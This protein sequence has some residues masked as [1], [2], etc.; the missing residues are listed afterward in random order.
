LS[1]VHL[2]RFLRLAAFGLA[3]TIIAWRPAELPPPPSQP[4]E[5]AQRV[6]RVAQVGGLMRAVLIEPGGLTALAA[7]GESLLRIQAIGSSLSVR[8]RLD[9]GL[10]AINDLASDGPSRFALTE[11][12]LLVMEASGDGL[13][14][15]QAFVPGGGQAIAASGG[16]ALIAAREAG[17]RIVDAR[18]PQAPQLALTLPLSGD[19]QDVAIA[20]GGERVYV[21]GGQAGVHVIDLSNP[22]D[23]RLERSLP[24]P[25]PVGAVAAVGGLI[26][27]A[28]DDRVY[29]LDP[30]LGKDAVVGVY[31]PLRDGR[32]LALDRGYA[33]VADADGGLKIY[34][35][36]NDLPPLQVYGDSGRLAFDVAV[37]NKVAYVAAG[38][39]G[40]RT[41]AVGNPA[42][43][44]ELARLPLPGPALGLSICEGRAFVALGPE[45]LAVVDVSQ[46]GRPA[47]LTRVPLVGSA[48]AV[49]AD[50]RFAYIAAGEGGLVLVSADRP[51]HEA[52]F[53]RLELPGHA[54]DVSRRGNVVFV[55]AGQAGLFAV[56]VTRPDAP[57]LLGD[58]L[59]ESP[60]EGFRSV[61]VIGKHALLATGDALVIADV[62][63]PA[64]MAQLARLEVPAIAAALD[65]I[66]LYVLGGRQIS[67]YD[68]RA[69]AAP[70]L[71]TAYRPI[72]RVRHI[73]AQGYHLF[74]TNA[75]DGSDVLALDLSFPDKPR[76][77]GLAGTHGHTFQALA[78]G[79]ALW[80]AAGQ[81]GLERLSIGED[82]RL[83]PFGA[84]S[85]VSEATH[86]TLTGNLILTGGDDGWS[87]M[88][89]G[90]PTPLPIMRG[91]EGL[92]ARAIVADPSEGLLVVAA[93]DGV[94]AYDV[95]GSAP[96]EIAAQADLGPATG[97]ALDEAYLYVSDATGWLHLLRRDNLGPVMRV[98]LPS[99][100]N[101]VALRDAPDGRRLAFVPL[102]GGAL[103]LTDVTDPSG[104]V[105]SLAVHAG[106][107]AALAAG[108]SGSLIYALADDRLTLLDAHDPHNLTALSETRLTWCGDDILLADRRLVVIRPGRGATFYD[109]SQPT[110]PQR[111]DSIRL[112]IEAAW[113]YQGVIYLAEGR[114]GLSW[115][116]EEV[117]LPTAAR[118]RLLDEPVNA[119]LIEGSTLYAVGRSLSIWNVSQ[120]QQ[121]EPVAST[122]LTGQGRG[123]T[124][125]PDGRLYVA[126]DAGLDIVAMRPTGLTIEGSLLVYGGGIEGMAL[127]AGRA[128]LAL[129]EHGLLVADVSDPARPAAL[130]TYTSPIGRAARDVT[131]LGDGFL[132][133]SW[134]GGQETLDV[135]QPVPPPQVLDVLDLPSSA[136]DMALDG[137]RAAVALGQE[138]V[139]LLN[140]ADPLAPQTIGWLDTPGDG[141]GVALSGEVLYV[142]DGVC[143]LRVFDVHDPTSPSERG[144]WRGGIAGDVS[145]GPAPD[146][147]E[148]IYLADGNALVVLRYLP[149]AEPALPPM[150]LDPS[151]QNGAQGVDLSVS[152][153]WGPPLDACDPL[154][155]QVY[156]GP[157]A[158]PPSLGA[159]GGP[160]HFDVG[161]LEPL[162][163]YFW[164]VNVAD[165]QGEQTSGP[166]WQF[167]TRP[168]QRA[169][170][171][172]PAPPIFRW[173]RDHPG[174]P[175]GLVALLIGS[176]IVAYL[177]RRPADHRHDD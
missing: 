131:L 134:D 118:K 112:A 138:G 156:F 172:L 120:P 22:A 26:A 39:E 29:V 141:R 78:S 159:F 103:A 8:D 164:R 97:L 94:H 161:Q 83:T 25:E 44:L 150:P 169:L 33:Y 110:H 79:D 15:Q 80:L 93:G 145:L 55:A 167:T 35:L 27:A 50:R 96:A 166:L 116:T 36:S 87:M 74:L 52:M 45:G 5:A 170:D 10:G 146:G 139:A 123:L 48:N 126:T 12:G 4:G 109:V 16:Y 43:P 28:G 73:S 3:L 72:E 154:T 149:N 42:R 127:A 14:V 86:V 75:E 59:P 81:V 90:Q 99:G 173:V 89:A 124:I 143:G 38:D 2:S 101:G 47:L 46:P 85:P 18:S 57:A 152:L 136:L 37:E 121:P 82:G 132:L 177:T 155:Y 19:A 115:L 34:V 92:S 171:F 32:R 68:A 56:D 102:S 144:Y 140:L 158:D 162:T 65:R 175:L 84:Y 106:R 142:A 41:L 105:R 9:P 111:G 100:A 108:P 147:S 176:G 157:E 160:P 163:T 165:R 1:R 64:Y 77:T 113:P 168:P 49:S 6:E 114:G 62:A 58:L 104:G 11:G 91:G 88:D 23:A 71:V 66:T 13:P 117:P 128:Y 135:S 95:S 98:A 40:L 151:P 130:F 107:G 63:D 30:S 153:A 76:E 137:D 67:L 17:L 125:G 7:E 31:S 54:L 129:S 60:Q 21:A 61:R 122:S 24:T 119:L 53:S 51:G 148:R 20:P 70:E 69:M 174:V 133:V